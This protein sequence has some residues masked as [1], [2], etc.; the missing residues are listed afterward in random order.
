MSAK[1]PL[2]L[3]ELLS[4]RTNVLLLTGSLCDDVDFD[5]EKLS[6]YAAAISIKLNAPVAATANTPPGLKASG[7]KSVKKMW[8][9]E[10]INFMRHPWQDPIMEQ[11]PEVLVFIG[12]PPSVA[13]SLT[14]AVT[15][16][17][18]VVLGN[19][20]VKEATCSLPESSSLRQWQ[21]SLEQFIS[22]L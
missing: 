14:S 18:T 1:L 7:G 16:A 19:T 6:D 13:S 2:E 12:Y 5:G 17:E 8:A 3:A 22:K 4:K 11:K 21:Q 20:Y 10:V 15:E 9:A